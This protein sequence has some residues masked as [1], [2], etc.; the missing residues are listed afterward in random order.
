MQ[1]SH[2]L[3]VLPDPSSVYTATKYELMSNM[4]QMIFKP[5]DVMGS[6]LA[7]L[8]A[9]NIGLSPGPLCE[10]S[11]HN[12]CIDRLDLRY[13]IQLKRELVNSGGFSIIYPQVDGDKFEHLINH[14][15]R[16][17]QQGPSAIRSIR[18]S[19]LY[20]NLSSAILKLHF[21]N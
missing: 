2:E 9:L 16:R 15:H 3:G 17:I 8:N 20:H 12:A 18:T 14:I 11:S 21:L 10:P 1:L 13:L 7:D 5:T 4:L 6:L 19:Y